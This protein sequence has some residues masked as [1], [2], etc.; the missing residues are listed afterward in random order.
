MHS[1]AVLPYYEVIR[2]VKGNQQIDT[3]ESRQLILY[4][5]KVTSK[6]HT[7]QLHEVMDMT[8]RKFGE[9]GLLYLYTKSGVFTFK[10]RGGR[11]D[12]F[13]KAYHTLSNNV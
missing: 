9:S 5:D 8:F 6:H 2:E 7:F 1:V 10:M 4:T 12:E 3:E 13:L 11:P